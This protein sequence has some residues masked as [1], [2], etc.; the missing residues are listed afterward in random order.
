MPIKRSFEFVEGTSSKFWEIEQVGATVP[1]RFGR[2]GTTGQTKPKKFANE[3][4]AKRAAEK[5]IA[6]KT[7]GGYVERGAAAPAAKAAKAATTASSGSA[8]KT[9]AKKV[10]SGT[11]A[12]LTA[13][14]EG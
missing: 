8:T 4:E 12:L 5:L 3:A 10:G 6:E 2:I 7:K 14:G 13:L 9:T 1:V 11:A